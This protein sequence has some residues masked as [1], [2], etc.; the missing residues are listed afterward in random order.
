MMTAIFLI[1]SWVFILFGLIGFYRFEN[2]YMKIL[3]AGKIDTV[4]FFSVIIGMIFHQGLSPE[5]LKLFF[6]LL[7]FLI[8]NPLNSQF[9]GRSAL[10]NGI[11]VKEGQPIQTSPVGEKAKE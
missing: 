9:I 2:I 8:T 1:I 7:F 6:I 11:P 3:I 5:S 4:A 10:V